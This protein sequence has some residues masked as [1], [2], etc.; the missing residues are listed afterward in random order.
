ML[1]ELDQNYDSVEPF[2]KKLLDDAVA[3]QKK[4]TARLKIISPKPSFHNQQKEA[5]ETKINAGESFV[6]GLETKDVEHNLE[7]VIMIDDAEFRSIL[8]DLENINDEISMLS[9]ARPRFSTQK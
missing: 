6:N 7:S 9:T 2:F 1:S 3:S 4:T 5:T 8:E